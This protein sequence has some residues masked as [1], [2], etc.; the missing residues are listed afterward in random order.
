MDPERNGCNQSYFKKVFEGVKAGKKDAIFEYG[1][2]LYHGTCIEKNEEQ[3]FLFFAKSAQEGHVGAYYN[4]ALM[5]H[6]GVG[7]KEDKKKATD[8]FESLLETQ[9]PPS[10]D[11][12][13]SLESNHGLDVDYWINHFD[14]NCD[15]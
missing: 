12:V 8:M 7:T 9:Y 14:L 11:Y 5:Y 6:L 4:V 2:F 15:N 3:A 10:I 1:K 13:C